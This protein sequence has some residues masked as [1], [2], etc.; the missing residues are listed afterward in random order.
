MGLREKVQK[1]IGK[2][3]EEVRELESQIVK[4][5]AYIQA[6][7]D[8]LKMIP[9]DQEPSSTEV[10]LRHGSLVAKAR[11]LSVVLEN[12]YMSVKFWPPWVN[13]KAR[14]IELG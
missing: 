4:C 9:K 2:R 1:E 6:F 5:N 11:T 3:Q 8:T 7:Q 12:L 13:R 14:K 10:T